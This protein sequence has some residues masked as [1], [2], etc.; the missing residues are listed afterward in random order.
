[1][2]QIRFMH[3]LEQSQGVVLS[4]TSSNPLSEVE[5]SETKCYV[6]M[7]EGRWIPHCG[8]LNNR[9]FD[10]LGQQPQ[11]QPHGAAKRALASTGDLRLTQ[12]GQIDPR[13]S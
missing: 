13:A 4:A 2:V 7:G 12:S 1:M 3:R 9:H 8:D 10:S 5:H 6:E 11:H